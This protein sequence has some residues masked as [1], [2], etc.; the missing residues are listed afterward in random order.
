VNCDETIDELRHFNLR[1]IQPR[2]GYRFS[3]D[4]LLL[5]AF[6]GLRAGE[7]VID[8]GTGCGVIPLVLAR[9]TADAAIVGVEFQEEMAGLAARNAELNG[10]Q[11]RVEIVCD[12]VLSLR[13]RFPVSS[14]D[15]V[16]ANPPYRVPGTGR[17]SPKAGRDAAR[18]ETTATLKDFLEVAKYLVKPTG[19][20]AFI[21]HPSRLA[22]FIT[23]AGALKL[24]PL[25]LR[26]V[27]GNSGMEARMFL[28][29]LAKS[30]KGELEVMPPLFVYDSNGQ[31][32]KEMKRILG[33]QDA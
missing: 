7:R 11:E 6:A 3:L 23:Q 30:R 19:R 13:K 25:R 22:E 33:E 31:Y 14:F 29:E 28:I 20:I 2:D 12:D 15:L 26:M 21:Y 32:S 18:H 1:I 5:C 8:L 24:A 16:V 4:S 27:H 9:Q 17:I 10:L